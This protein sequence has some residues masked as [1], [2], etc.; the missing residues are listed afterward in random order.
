VICLFTVK[1][2]G[3][4]VYFQSFQGEVVIKKVVIE[5]FVAKSCTQCCQIW[6]I[7]ANLATLHTKF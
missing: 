3:L 5:I 6:L 4:T 7:V 2:Y 1:K